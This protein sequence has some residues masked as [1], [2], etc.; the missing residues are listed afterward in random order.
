MDE[1]A[2]A[3]GTVIGSD[4]E[5][6]RRLGGGGMGSVYLARQV[7]TDKLRA[8]KV[9][10]ARYAG[11]E[12]FL[13]RFTLEAKIGARI[14]S[15]HVVEVIA[16]G[17]EPGLEMPWLAMQFLEGGTLERKMASRGVPARNTAEVLLRQL[18]HALG[19]AHDAAI[20]H[21]DLKP[22]NLFLG[23]ASGPFAPFT[24]RVLDFGI[25]KWLAQGRT[26]TE[27]LLTLGWGAPEQ[28]SAGGQIGP[29]ADIWA[30]GLLVFWLVTGESYWHV[31]RGTHALL[32]EMLVDPLQPASQRA[33]ELGAR[34]LPP[35]FDSWFSR[36]VARDPAQRFAHAREAERALEA[37][38]LQWAEGSEWH[39]DS[40][41]EAA[42]T[43]ASPM[44]RDE[45]PVT[46][47]LRSST[48][49]AVVFEPNA[50]TT[51]APAN[52]STETRPRASSRAWLGVAAAVAAIGVAAW[53]NLPESGS[54]ATAPSASAR[55]AAAELVPP[56]MRTIPA[57]TPFLLDVEEVD[58]AHYQ[59]CV[60]A[61]SC[62]QSSLVTSDPVLGKSDAYR[63]LCNE[64]YADRGRHPINC[65]SRAQATAYCRWLGKRLPTEAEWEFAARGGTTR[66]YPWGDAAPETCEMA[67][68][69]GLCTRNP[70][71]T[72]PAGSRQSS[73]QSAQGLAD[74]SGN[75]WEW[76]SDGVERGV[77]RGGGWDYAADRATTSARLEADPAHADVSMGF[78]C[79]RS[80]AAGA[81]P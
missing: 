74:L 30:V 66:L 65:V 62:T 4:F 68:V 3:P 56:E 81:R 34:A 60:Q 54:P 50:V 20:V 38:G 31:E 53:R 39:F 67:V 17:I 45:I 79:A 5:V 40:E 46:K 36:C 61:G 29:Q 32:R 18:F 8:L 71:A 1:F 15:E 42:S 6:I 57:S 2:L 78:R 43:V 72:R 12:S 24:L 59:G 27:G 37:V 77:L 16:A 13:R 63:G 75:V 23:S 58:T 28:T 7:S 69:S 47:P 64:R 33:A 51:G 55:G 26:G 21:R 10:R 80:L 52:L 11:D 48:R 73:A 70:V 19:A 41:L 9:M 35:E 14:K 49:A 44:L 22:E 76:V 25:A